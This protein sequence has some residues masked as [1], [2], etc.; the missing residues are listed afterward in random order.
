MGYNDHAAIQA[1]ALS[2]FAAGALT[3]PAGVDLHGIG[4]G[5]DPHEGQTASQGDCQPHVAT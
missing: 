5:G 3:A 1:L 2:R 4:L